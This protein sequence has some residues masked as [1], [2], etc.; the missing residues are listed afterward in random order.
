MNKAQL[1]AR[2][3]QLEELVQLQGVQEVQ[4]DQDDQNSEEFWSLN[5]DETQESG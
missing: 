4:E 2:I 5:E 3:R 1:Q